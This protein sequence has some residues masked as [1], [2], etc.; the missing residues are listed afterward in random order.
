MGRQRHTFFLIILSSWVQA[1]C[2]QGG[3]RRP[4]TPGPSGPVCVPRPVRCRDG[5]GGGGDG[6]PPGAS[7]G[8][9]VWRGQFS[10]VTPKS[11]RRKGSR[12]CPSCLNT[13]HRCLRRSLLGA[14]YSLTV[15]EDLITLRL[16]EAQSPGERYLDQTPR[17]SFP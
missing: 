8:G 4:E 3:E 11:C 15:D 17:G 5:G 10:P 6:W 14:T 13:M 9:W 7:D 1:W 12:P 2:Y 16:K